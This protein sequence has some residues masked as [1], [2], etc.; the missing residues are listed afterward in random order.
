MF[1]GIVEEVGVVVRVRR[2]GPALRLEVGAPGVSEGCRDGDSV[3]VSGV[4]L[5][6]VSRNG[7]TLS[8]DAVPET[9][10]RSSLAGLSVGQRVNLERAVQVG[11]RLGGHI[12]QGHVDGVAVIGGLQRAALGWTIRCE[13]PRELRRYVAEKGSVALDGISLTVAAVRPGDFDV[14]VIPYTWQHTT[15]SDRRIGDPLNLEVDVLAR[16]VER[17]LGDE[18]AG[19]SLTFDALASAGFADA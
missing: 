12:V 3:S 15:L 4:C 10:A 9:V 19:K 7:S 11:G 6:V 5:T 8:F 16:Y 1:T 13:A 18:R 17:L 2:S 14:A